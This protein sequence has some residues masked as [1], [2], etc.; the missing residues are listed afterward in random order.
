MCR[1][2][3]AWL[4][5]FSSCISSSAHRFG[6]GQFCVLSMGCPPSGTPPQ[7]DGKVP[8]AWNDRKSHIFFA[9]GKEECEISKK[10][11][12]RRTSTQKVSRTSWPSCSH[13]QAVGEPGNPQQQ[14]KSGFI[15]ANLN[16]PIKSVCSNCPLPSVLYNSHWLSGCMAG[17]GSVHSVF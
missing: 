7:R 8:G 12:I 3:T 15:S 13:P 2:D 14:E 6:V 1:E 16:I 10:K 5:P 11:T 4:G 17:T 9:K